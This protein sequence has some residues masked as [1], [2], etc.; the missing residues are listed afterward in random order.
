MRKRESMTAAEAMAEFQRDPEFSARQRKL[1]EEL[2]AGTAADRNAQAPVLEALANVGVSVSSVWDMANT[3]RVDARALPVLFE[4][5]QLPYPAQIREGMARA[6]A[7]PEARFAWPVL[8]GMFRQEQDR[9]VKDGLAVALSGIASDDLLDELIALARDPTLGESRVLLLFAL[10]HS[11]RNG[12]KE[13]LSE[14]AADSQLKKE[15]R[16]IVRRLKRA[17]PGY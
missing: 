6:M 4:H 15:A 5:L 1:E 3:G 11:P 8:V 12:M 7:V 2:R 17:H 9:R 16:A 14:L 10:E 13:V